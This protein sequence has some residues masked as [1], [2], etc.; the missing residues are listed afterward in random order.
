MDLV[1]EI[2]YNNPYSPGI[3]C[4][5]Q[6]PVPGCTPLSKVQSRRPLPNFGGI[7]LWDPYGFS[8]YNGLQVKMEKRFSHGVAILGSFT[9]M[10]SLDIG[11]DDALGYNYHMDALNS[12]YGPSDMD[13]PARLNITYLWRLPVGQGQYWAP[14]SRVL[15][16]VIGGW[17]L[18]GVTTYQSGFPFWIGY[19]NYLDNIGV[20]QL[21][22]RVCNGKLSNRNI[23]EWYNPSCFVSPIPPNL[24]ST[25]SYGFQGNVARGILLGP[26]FTN[27]NVGFMKNFTTYEKQYLQVRAEFDNAFND[28]NFGGPTTT[29]GPG[30]TNPAT[31]SSA[32]PPRSIQ[33]V[34]KYYF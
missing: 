4:A 30:I 11:S 18:S 1:D 33:M 25:Y 21:P 8:T 32:G 15:D 24:Q 9:W 23:Q 17:E 6:N 12:W 27:W 34:M 5:N 19:S 22:N 10:K 3:L 29:V 13:S 16:E 7:T 20:P 28:V 14:R 26:H 31:I 2:G